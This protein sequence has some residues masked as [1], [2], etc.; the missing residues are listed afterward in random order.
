MINIGILGISS[1]I[2]VVMKQLLKN[3]LVSAHLLDPAKFLHSFFRQLSIR[4]LQKEFT[5]RRGTL[6]DGYP[7]PPARQI[8]LV[9][10]SV[11]GWEY[12]ES[13]KK[14]VDE[15]SAQ[16]QRKNIPDDSLKSILDFGCG[17]GRM[18]RHLRRFPNATLFGTD[19]NRE[20]IEWSA[21]E[22]PFISFGTNMLHPPLSYADGM[23]DLIIA[24]SVFT[25]LDEPLQ[26]AWMKE[27]RRVLR[28]GGYLYCT[29]HSGT[30][31]HGF[32]DD[33]QRRLSSEGFVTYH[34]S[35]QGDNKCATYQ[36]KE[37]VLAN[38]TEGFE[39]TEHLPGTSAEHLGQDIFLFRKR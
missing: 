39:V 35:V 20:L 26:R 22:L 7:A 4:S 9:I 16:L 15:L 32:A 6:P 12:W 1:D 5:I 17:C 34:S 38:L 25:H 21:R 36:T 3:I 11:W 27:W 37:W 23:F 33:F 14:I 8:F 31:T 24:R 30:S 13:G 2:V 19:Y 29:T 28:P 18:T 10:R